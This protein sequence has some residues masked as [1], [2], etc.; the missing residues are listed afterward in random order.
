[1]KVRDAVRTLE[2]QGFSLKRTRG[3]HRQFQGAVNGQ[4]RLVTVAGKEG[5][6]V[7]RPTL[8]SIVPDRPVETSIRPQLGQEGAIPWDS[9]KND[10]AWRSLARLS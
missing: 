2:E 6:D 10:R 8:V 3:S 9:R 5:D 4:R 7:A 1:M